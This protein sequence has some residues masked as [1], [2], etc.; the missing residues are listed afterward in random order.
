MSD[1][2]HRI[3]K[4]ASLRF[5][6]TRL[7]LIKR[8]ARPTAQNMRT[9]FAA[10]L[11]LL[12]LLCRTGAEVL[13]AEK[14]L[15]DD[16]LL[17]FTL[18]DFNKIRDIY[19]HSPHGRFWNDPAMKDFKDKFINKLTAD[20]I[21]PLEHAL[22]VRFADYTNLAQGQF[23]FALVQNGWQGAAGQSPALVMLLDTKDQSAQ[24]KTNLADLKKK[25]VDSGKTIQTE[26]IHGIDFSAITPSL[27]EVS[28]AVKKPL[29]TL[30]NGETVEP[31]DD[32]DNKKAPKNKLYIGQVESLLVVGD[33]PK[34]LE[35]ILVRMSG[36]PV[37]TLS[38][39]A[40]F[41]A[42]AGMFHD[43]PAFGW[44]NTK[45]FIDVWSHPAMIRRTP[46]PV[47]PA[48]VQDRTKSF[49]HS[50]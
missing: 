30:A 42:N 11:A 33:S 31:M 40:G 3:S 34:V 2:V 15:P 9:F 39:V 43:V 35:K 47:K 20:Y 41:D 5:R 38:D 4:P 18:P 25:W 26:T 6:A 14:A 36:G 50:D 45:A 22:G 28:K 48:G 8:P 32:P 29:A 19:Q 16:T 49:P 13:P 37:K 21:T 24:L 23:T 17:M 7:E 12:C 44:I 1:C 46:M 27:G 10:S